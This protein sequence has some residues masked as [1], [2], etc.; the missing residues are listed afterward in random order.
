MVDGAAL[1]TGG[2]RGI[3][4]A[5]AVALARTARPVAI[6]YLARADDA[7]ETR[8]MIEQAGGEAACFQADVST[9][10]GVERLFAEVEDAFGQVVVLVNNAGVRR[11]GLLLT[12]SDDAWGEVIATNLY[13]PF[14]CC[15]RALRGMLK[16]RWGRIVNVSSVAGLHGS[17]GQ[18][19]YAAA[20]AGMIGLTK[21]LAREVARKNITVN[22][23]APGPIATDLTAD[24]TDAQWE[25]LRAEVPAARAGTADEVASLIAYLC[26]EDSSFITGGVFTADGGMTA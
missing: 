13:G 17:P 22:V 16:S 8:R 15:R 11:D 9:G 25:R 3:G 5:T 6:N 24:L 14:A 4:R 19:N 1:V 23:V 2:A 26:S 21:T 7:K 18:S 10:A 20:K 12:L